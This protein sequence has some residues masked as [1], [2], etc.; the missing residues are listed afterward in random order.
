M[1]QQTPRIQQTSRPRG[2]P[3]QPMTARDS[4]AIL[5]AQDG[6]T[7]YEIAEVLRV[8]S[9]AVMCVLARA[10][11]SAITIAKHKRGPKRH[12]DWHD[13]LAA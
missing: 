5:A 3:K 10:R 8:S 11:K 7:S 4:I 13:R 1:I 2:R 9:A 6:K 12:I